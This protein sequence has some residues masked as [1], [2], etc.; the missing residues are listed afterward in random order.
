MNSGVWPDLSVGY[1]MRLE[2]SQKVE[3]M[4]RSFSQGQETR[5][6]GKWAAGLS[7]FLGK[8]T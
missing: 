2:D 7:H 1:M 6:Q 4:G 3:E 5:E 8:E